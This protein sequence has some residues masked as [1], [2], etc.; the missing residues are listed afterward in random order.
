MTSN[1]I[2]VI[3]ITIIKIQLQ[4]NKVYQS[5]KKGDLPIEIMKQSRAKIHV[6]TLKIG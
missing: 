5:Y 6:S 2:N 3:N 4:K 1:S